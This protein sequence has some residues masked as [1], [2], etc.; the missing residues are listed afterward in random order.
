MFNFNRYQEDTKHML[1]DQRKKQ[2][3]QQ[4]LGFKFP[5][6]NALGDPIV[7]PLVSI[8]KWSSMTSKSLATPKKIH[9][10]TVP[11]VLRIEFTS[12]FFLISDT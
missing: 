8:L 6:R 10:R 2:Q 5:I 12:P 3:Q 4:Q 7:K 11:L 9:F 1:E